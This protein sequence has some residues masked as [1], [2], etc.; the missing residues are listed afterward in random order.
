MIENYFSKSTLHLKEM[1]QDSQLTFLTLLDYLVLIV[2]VLLE[3][4]D[5]NLSH[6][7]AINTAPADGLD[8]VTDLPDFHTPTIYFIICFC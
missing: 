5:L 4:V 7:P 3:S 1:F 2:C 6:L 8:T